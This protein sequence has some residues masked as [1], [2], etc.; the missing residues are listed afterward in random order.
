M[1]ARPSRRPNLAG[2][3]RGAATVLAALLIAAVVA[4]AGSGFWVGAAVVARHRAQAAADL[5]A[6]GAAAHLPGGAGVACR[7]AR[8]VA[9]AM[10]AA[11]RACEIDGLDVVV[12]VSTAAGG[13]IA[14]LAA[15]SARA[16][17]T[18]AG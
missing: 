3:D 2:E 12:T 4:V 18:V 11:V 17:P 10:G 16:G 15:A 6:L 5:A 9:A 7:Q 8:I 14:R 13:R 1:S